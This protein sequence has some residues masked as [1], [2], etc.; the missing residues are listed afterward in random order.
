MAT[1]LGGMNF[2]GSIRSSDRR[3]ASSTTGCTARKGPG[4]RSMQKPIQLFPASVAPTCAAFLKTT[5]CSRLHGGSASMIP[6]KK[7]YG[8]SDLA[9]PRR[10]SE[11]TAPAAGWPN[12]ARS[13][14][15]RGRGQRA[16]CG[17]YCPRPRGLQQGSSYTSVISGKCARSTSLRA[18][19]A[20]HFLY[21]ALH[22]GL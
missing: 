6:R 10:P 8:W 13:A 16:S 20:D 2:G 5:R 11:T 9:R 1:C 12:A 18:L 7:V 15:D 4:A 22:V 3:L 17:G 21:V 19:D 14:R